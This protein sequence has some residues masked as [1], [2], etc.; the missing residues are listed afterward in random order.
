MANGT[1]KNAECILHIFQIVKFSAGLDLNENKSALFFSKGGNHKQQIA[2]ILNIT[3]GNIPVIYLGIPLFNKL[4]AKDFGDL[5]DKINKKISQWNSEMHNT[6][7]KI[8]LVKTV[9]HPMVQF[10]LQFTQFSVG[11]IQRISYLCANFIWK[12]KAQKI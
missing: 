2:D 3:I 6:S 9:I 12:S 5:I 10:W 7:G 8:E 4:K 11:I 1:K